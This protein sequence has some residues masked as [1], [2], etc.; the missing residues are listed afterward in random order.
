MRGA[1]ALRQPGDGGGGDAPGLKKLRVPK[2]EESVSPAIE[3]LYGVLSAG[4]CNEL[5]CAL[6]IG[7]RRWHP[8]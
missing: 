6:H 3:A 4:A 8:D 1:S 5:T 7:R 2:E